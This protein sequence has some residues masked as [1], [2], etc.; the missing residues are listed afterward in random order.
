MNFHSFGV[1]KH[2]PTKYR[3]KAWSVD[4]KF[5]KVE[6]GFSYLFLLQSNSEM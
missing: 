4:Y 6:Q 3:R 5:K 2:Y 1:E